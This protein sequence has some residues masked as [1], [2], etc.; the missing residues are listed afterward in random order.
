MKY[1]KDTFPAGSLLQSIAT[2]E[3]NAKDDCLKIRP[4]SVKLNQQFGIGPMRDVP[5]ADT[6]TFADIYDYFGGGTRQPYRQKTD[7]T[8]NGELAVKLQN[9]EVRQVQD[10]FAQDY[11]FGRTS[12]LPKVPVH[13]DTDGELLTN[14]PTK[15]G[16]IN[17]YI[18]YY[19]GQ[20]ARQFV[21]VL[22][23]KF[24]TDDF[25]RQISQA[26]NAN[27]VAPAPM[28]LRH[29]VENVNSRRSVKNHNMNANQHTPYNLQLKRGSFTKMADK[30]QAVNPPPANLISA[31]QAMDSP[32]VIERK[33]TS[34]SNPAPRLDRV[35]NQK[36]LHQNVPHLSTRNTEG[37]IDGIYNR[38]IVRDSN[39]FESQFSTDFNS[40]SD[41]NREANPIYGLQ[42]V[43]RR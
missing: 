18:D 26:M 42:T 13:F 10:T 33:G 34:M 9:P 24:Q 7:A 11:S 16:A 35:N 37:E 28:M 17:K 38:T 41:P 21:G 8:Y 40:V 30:A 1:S 31:P 32:N 29:S 20:A 22:Q 19:A 36:N 12:Y 2:G 39:P 5:P 15:G 27:V 14:I 43:F 4:C 3:V 23:K 25:K 6:N